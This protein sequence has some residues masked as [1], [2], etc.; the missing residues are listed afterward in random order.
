[1]TGNLT[2]PPRPRDVPSDKVEQSLRL[3]SE[4]SAALTTSL[5]L[6]TTIDHVAHVIVP[7]LADWC[8]V[9]LVEGEF[10]GIQTVVRR[11][12][13]VHA[14]PERQRLV[15][16]LSRRYPPCG[17]RPTLS[18]PVIETGRSVL[19]AE[20][21]DEML[22]AMAR[23]TEQ[24]DL[25]RRIGLRSYMV[26]PLLARDRLLGIV[27]FLAS[28]RRC[29]ADDL[30]LAEELARRIGMA[31]DNARLFDQPALECHQVQ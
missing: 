15:D 31:V 3:L 14:D 12:A 28:H 4:A 17:D 23:D 25:V 22:D 26:A 29:D 27:A 20:L 9:D 19:V 10:R 30:L 5:D 16:E 1:M 11:A 13:A 18:G 21:K 2:A 6:S 7:A 8:V 24:A